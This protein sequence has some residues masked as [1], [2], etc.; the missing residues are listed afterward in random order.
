MIHDIMVKRGIVIPEYE[1]VKEAEKELAPEEEIPQ[2][3]AGKDE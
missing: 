1:E 2:T 3:T